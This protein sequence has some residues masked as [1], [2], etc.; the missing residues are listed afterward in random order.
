MKSKILILLFS[1]I[2]FSCGKNQYE[3]KLLGKWYSLNEK[4]KL[5][6]YQDS[7]FI[8]DIQNQRTSWYANE[9]ELKYKYKIFLSG[10]IENISLK[11][12]LNEQ[13]DS[14]TLFSEKQNLEP[15]TFI[16]SNS[17]EEFLQKK[18]NIKF[19]LPEN[20]KADYFRGNQHFEI[21]VFIGYMNKILTVKTEYSPNL[22]NLE[23]DFNLHILKNKNEYQNEYENYFG[24]DIIGFENYSRKFTYYSLFV[25]NNVSEKNIGKYIDLLKDSEIKTVYQIFKTEELNRSGMARYIHFN[26]LKGIRK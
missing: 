26:N 24:K 18:N 8:S 22:N 23:N 2:F 19:S 15:Q 1:I 13:E 17:F 11:Y 5:E 10:K 7:L 16:R 21:K 3:K 6:L 12:S 9:S 4:Y 25:D 14:L 20:Q